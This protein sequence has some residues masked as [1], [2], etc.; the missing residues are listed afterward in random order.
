MLS[1]S[2][3][4]MPTQNLSRVYQKSEEI[5]RSPDPFP[6]CT[7]AHPRWIPIW[8]RTCSSTALLPYGTSSTLNLNERRGGGV[9]ISEGA[10]CASKES[11]CHEKDETR[12]CFACR[13]SHDLRQGACTKAYA[14][15]RAGDCS[16]GS[17]EA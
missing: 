2:G 17:I 13:N 5:T 6:G 10:E 4:Q 7:S 9:W 3:S 16:A 14:Q 11:R 8:Q 15:I 1:F 12:F